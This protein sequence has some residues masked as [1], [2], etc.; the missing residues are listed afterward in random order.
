MANRAGRCDGIVPYG[1][2]WQHILAPVYA[3]LFLAIAA[4]ICPCSSP[5]PLTFLCTVATIVYSNRCAPVVA[6][7]TRFMALRAA[8]IATSLA[9]VV[10]DLQVL[11]DDGPWAADLE[12]EVGAI[13]YR[14][15]ELIEGR[16][17]DHRGLA[18]PA[19]RIKSGRFCTLRGR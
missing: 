6:G 8:P 3:D 5:Q 10:D 14:I 17:H 15:Y 4:L 2:H 16:D 9:E 1:Q 11:G 18:C 12:R 19:A 13:I 7:K